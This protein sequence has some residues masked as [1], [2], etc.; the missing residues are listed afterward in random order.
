[1]SS[2]HSPW[3]IAKNSSCT[4]ASDL[5][6]LILPQLTD[7]SAQ[8]LV[9]NMSDT[10]YDDAYYSTSCSE[11]HAFLCQSQVRIGTARFDRYD[12]MIVMESLLKD[13]HIKQTDITTEY[14][15]GSDLISI[16][17]N[18]LAF[19]SVY[20]G[21]NGTCVTYYL[22][23]LIWYPV[24]VEMVNHS[25]AVSFVKSTGHEVVAVTNA[26]YPVPSE[27]TY[28]DNCF[29]YGEPTVPSTKK[30]MPTRIDHS[31]NEEGSTHYTTSSSSSL[32]HSA[33]NNR[34]SLKIS[35]NLPTTFSSTETSTPNSHPTIVDDK[36]VTEIKEKSRETMFV[37]TTDKSTSRTTL[38]DSTSKGS[39]HPTT[40][41]DKTVTD[42]TDT[43]RATDISVITTDKYTPVPA[44]IDLTSSGLKT[45]TT[46]SLEETSTSGSSYSLSTDNVT[47]HSPSQKSHDGASNVTPNTSSTMYFYK[48]S[49]TEASE[50]QL[51][52]LIQFSMATINKVTT[53]PPEI[54]ASLGEQ[55][56]CVLA[57][58]KITEFAAK[59][60]DSL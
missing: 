40:V 22:E 33:E 53:A 44:F 7:Q 36:T 38:I 57:A 49:S 37:I 4:Q 19:A 58:D 51:C 21:N 3:L 5:L 10:S 55:N 27:N 50:L 25:Q 35:S 31:F 6:Q 46:A 16:D 47:V 17:T 34:I 1:M 60:L 9:L 14:I 24:R 59:Q 12:D 48:D 54:A 52:Y 8:C 13:V 30:S 15:C 23:K 41:Y 18:A 29:S 43:A 11:H 56:M 2:G 32:P 28:S 20:H 39:E 26:S 42:I 45:N